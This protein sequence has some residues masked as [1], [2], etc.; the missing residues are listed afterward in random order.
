MLQSGKANPTQQLRNVVIK[1][2]LQFFSIALLVSLFVVFSVTTVKADSTYSDAWL[3]DS[4]EAIAGCGVSEGSYMM[5]YWV[6]S[7]LTSPN[8]R[9]AIGYSAGGGD[10]RVYTA[11][12]ARADVFLLWD[13]SDV[14]DFSV[15][16]DHWLV[17]PD[18]NQAYLEAFVGSTFASLPLGISVSVLYKAGPPNPQGQIL[19]FVVANCNVRCPTYT[20]VSSD[21]KGEYILSYVARGPFG[22][23]NI[24][25]VV[26][27]ANN[28]SCY[29]LF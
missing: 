5:Q 7:S 8:G 26:V 3:D 17:C 15:T 28:G 1:A 21:Y 13:W 10:S 14:G 18:P 23:S 2:G 11:G 16:S 9:R 29:E 4:S 20:Y 27:N 12:Y 24:N 25:L 19:Y 22:C 6:Q